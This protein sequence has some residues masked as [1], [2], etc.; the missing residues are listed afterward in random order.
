MSSNFVFD[1]LP[2]QLLHPPRHAWDGPQPGLSAQSD[3][4]RRYY[5]SEKNGALESIV[6]YTADG[7]PEVRVR[8]RSGLHESSSLPSAFEVEVWRDG[9]YASAG[10]VQ[11]DGRVVYTHS[12]PRV[13]IDDRGADASIPLDD[14]EIFITPSGIVVRVVSHGSLFSNPRA[15]YV[16]RVKNFSPARPYTVRTVAGEHELEIHR[17]DVVFNPHGFVFEFKANGLAAIG[18]LVIPECDYMRPDD[19]STK[20]IDH[21][22]FTLHYHDRDGASV[23]IRDP[24]IAEML[25][26]APHSVVGR[27]TFLHQSVPEMVDVHGGDAAERALRA[28]ER[29]AFELGLIFFAL[30]N[31]QRPAF[32]TV[33]LKAHHALE[34]ALWKRVAE[35][36]RVVGADRHTVVNPQQ[37]RAWVELAA[38]HPHEALL[39]L[40]RSATPCYA[41]AT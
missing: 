25:D 17:S 35:F 31:E 23:E 12:L 21:D 40:K 10:L 5:F 38:Q 14:P 3:E 24:S 36:E 22:L 28:I 33:F 6:Q 16:G 11:K 20:K 9:S 7:F 29:S 37:I 1:N 27:H 26:G 39:E 34:D 4:T 2:E 32:R 19:E 8:Y 18:E 30:K 41:T 15:Q 13:M